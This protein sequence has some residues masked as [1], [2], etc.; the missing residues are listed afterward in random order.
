[1][2]YKIWQAGYPCFRAAGVAA[3]FASFVW[4][5]VLYP[6]L[7]FPQD[8]YEIVYEADEGENADAETAAAGKEAAGKEAAGAETDMEMETDEGVSLLDAEDEQIMIKSGLL[9]WLKQ[10]KRGKSF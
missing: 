4:W 10:H 7:S 5:C 6:E 2:R 9:E 1:M 3:V 8:T